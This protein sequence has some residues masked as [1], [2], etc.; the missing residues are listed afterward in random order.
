MPKPYSLRR[1]FADT[2]KLTHQAVVTKTGSDD[3]GVW[4]RLSETIFHPQGGGQPSDIGIIQGIKV[5]KVMNVPG[6]G[7][8]GAAGA[9][10]AA[11]SAED[12]INHYLEGASLEVVKVGT[13]VDCVVDF[14]TRMINAAR[15]TGGHLIAAV[16]QKEFGFKSQ[17][18][19][20]HFPERCSVKFPLNGNVPTPDDL[21]AAV[22][23]AIQAGLP[24][25]E[26]YIDGER[27]LTITGYRDDRCGGT[28]FDNTLQ[29][30]EMTLRNIKTKKGELSVGYDINYNPELV[31]ARVA[32]SEAEE[33]AKGVARLG[34]GAAK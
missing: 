9:T 31:K 4:V 15:H 10:A 26:Q 19:A 17:R 28:L 13:T 21:R 14:E 23:K 16:L 18:S 32:K 30:A 12:G 27:H 7:T 6:A 1:Y 8:V 24:I 11:A 20:D 2:Y 22:E 5:L 3:N 29:L 25:V 33:T 34:L